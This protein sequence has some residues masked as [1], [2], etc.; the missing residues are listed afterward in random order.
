MFELTVQEGYEKAP[1]PVTNFSKAH[2]RPRQIETKRAP[3][4]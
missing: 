3:I 1:I 2:H 4:S